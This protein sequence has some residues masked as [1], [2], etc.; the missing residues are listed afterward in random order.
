[1]NMSNGPL[2]DLIVFVKL[3][4]GKTLNLSKIYSW[5]VKILAVH[6]SSLYVHVSFLCVH[7]HTKWF[8]NRSYCVCK[9]VSRQDFKFE[10]NPFMDSENIGCAR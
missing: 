9:V 8:P 3:I 4:L 6:A 10:K 7:A 2:T 1:M 5:T